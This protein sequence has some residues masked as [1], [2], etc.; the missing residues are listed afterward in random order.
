MASLEGF[1]VPVL[2]YITNVGSRRVRRDD[3][4]SKSS[5]LPCCCSCDCQP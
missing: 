1:C 4:F 5:S 3:R 2:T